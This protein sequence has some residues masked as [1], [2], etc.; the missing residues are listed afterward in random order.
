MSNSPKVLRALISGAVFICEVAAC[1]TPAAEQTAV[2]PT[3]Q[4]DIVVNGK[5]LSDVPSSVVV[6]PAGGR[7]G[8]LATE[9][10]A[11]SNA[12]FFAR[13]IKPS[14]SEA[15]HEAIDG[16]PDRYISQNG[17]D[18]VIRAH[19]ACYRNLVSSPPQPQPPFYG[20]CHAISV[21]SSSTVCQSFFDHGTLVEQVLKTYAPRLDFT[22]AQLLDPSVLAR[23]REREARFA[24][25]QTKSEQT[26]FA[27]VACQV[28]SHPEI[29]LA[30]P[31]SDVDSKGEAVLRNALI[32]AAPECLRGGKEVIVDPY[33]YRVIVADAIYAWAVAL[34]GSDTL[35][36]N[37]AKRSTANNVGHN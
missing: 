36:P 30:Y 23:F 16:Q 34:R 18:K 3:A 37:L 32:G 5:S 24:K 13:C 31:R 14:D 9:G 4:P 19:Q 28:A 35:L 21:S 6:K 12:H 27:T 17:L 22:T 8:V 10:Q 33:E 7:G 29:A 11:S 25:T 2:A 1:A 20:Q 26:Y 15:L